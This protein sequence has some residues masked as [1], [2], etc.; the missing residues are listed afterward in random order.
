MVTP[1]RRLSSPMRIRAL[2][3]TLAGLLGD[4]GQTLVTDGGVQGTQ[5]YGRP[6]RPNQSAPV[7]PS[8]AVARPRALRHTP[9]PPDLAAADAHASTA[10]ARGPGP[11]ALPVANA[12]SGRRTRVMDGR[13]GNTR[14]PMAGSQPAGVGPGGDRRDGPRRA[15]RARAAVGRHDQRRL[16]R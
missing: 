2:G 13:R 7:P 14:R 8:D 5:P 4:S 6:L 15:H 16:V 3:V 12:P 11:R 9:R 1:V 10:A